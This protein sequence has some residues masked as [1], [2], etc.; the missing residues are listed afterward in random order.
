MSRLVLRHVD[1]LA[2]FDDAGTEH[3]DCDLVAHDG[4]ITAVGPG[5][6]EAEPSAVRGETIVP[7]TLTRLDS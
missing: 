1:H 4:V 7:S 3:R 2:T 6:A 5:V